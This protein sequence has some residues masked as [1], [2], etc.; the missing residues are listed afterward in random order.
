MPGFFST[1]FPF[2]TITNTYSTGLAAIL[3]F[4][5]KSEGLGDFSQLNNE[6]TRTLTSWLGSWESTSALLQG[7]KYLFF[8]TAHY[9][10]FYTSVEL[11]QKREIEG[12]VNTEYPPYVT[13]GFIS[14]LA[15]LHTTVQFS[16]K[17]GTEE[18]RHN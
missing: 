18:K 11:H 9:T 6:T 17:P 15:V 8:N 7:Q 2:L 10:V 16:S 4:C 5:A 12:I 3:H 1:N 14:N 13:H